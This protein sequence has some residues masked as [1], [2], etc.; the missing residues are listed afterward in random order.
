MLDKIINKNIIPIY[1]VKN[2]K[3]WYEIDSNKDL[4]LA[5]NSIKSLYNNFE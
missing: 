1:G 4:R 3:P 2:T 5:K